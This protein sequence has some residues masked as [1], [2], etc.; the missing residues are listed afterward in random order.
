MESQV[1]SVV[2]GVLNNPEQLRVDLERM[3]E[4]EQRNALR[5]DPELETKA[6][7]DKLAEVDQERR[8]YQKLAA[9]GRMTDEELDEALA[10][11][12]VIRETAE[13][14][15]KALRECR[16]RLES[17][18]RDKET[19]LN[20]YTSLAP[21]ALAS[22]DPEERHQLYKMLRLK[23]AVNLDGTLEFGGELIHGLE[24]CH[25]GASS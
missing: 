22:L 7:L 21:E 8:G 9:K 15:L 4:L 13:R 14:E 10:E 5:R 3:I 24:V 16:E 23:V 1:W 20:T 6:W 12:E 25:V 19:I 2:Y 17:L 18:E 11:L